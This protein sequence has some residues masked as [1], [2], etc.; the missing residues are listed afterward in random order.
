MSHTESLT[1]IERRL[2]LEALAGNLESAREL[3]YFERF[4]DY[5]TNLD[6]CPEAAEAYEK[7]RAQ[8]YENADC[9]SADDDMGR[10]S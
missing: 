7:A 6:A 2:E 3:A 4:S 1:G 8:Y 10:R 5:T 9:D